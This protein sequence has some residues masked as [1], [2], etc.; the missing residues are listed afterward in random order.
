M[1]SSYTKKGR[2][3]LVISALILS[4]DLCQRLYHGC[5]FRGFGKEFE[6]QR[7]FPTSVKFLDRVELLRRFLADRAG[8]KLL[9]K[10]L[11]VYATVIVQDVRVPLRKRNGGFI[12]AVCGKCC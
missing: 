12:A 11:G 6:K 3:E 1:L 5:H 10:P 9:L 7:L 8:V 2:N 4:H